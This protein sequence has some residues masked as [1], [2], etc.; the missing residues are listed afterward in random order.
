VSSYPNP[1]EVER[2]DLPALATLD[3][4]QNDHAAVGATTRVPGTWTDAWEQPDG[5]VRLTLAAKG[6][7]SQALPAARVTFVNLPAWQTGE[8]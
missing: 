8:Y 3:V 6:S 4:H 5:S 2:L 7:R 1:F